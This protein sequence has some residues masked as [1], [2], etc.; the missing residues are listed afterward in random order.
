MLHLAET[1]R[2]SLVSQTGLCWPQWHSQDRKTS[3]Q[4]SD[5][6]VLTVLYYTYYR[7]TIASRAHGGTKCPTALPKLVLPFCA[8]FAGTETALSSPGRSVANQECYPSW[9]RHDSSST[10]TWP[11]KYSSLA[12]LVKQSLQ[13]PSCERCGK[14]AASRPASGLLKCLGKHLCLTFLL[15]PFCLACICKP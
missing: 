7:P 11:C 8:T 13:S 3:P 2:N 10:P 12:L 1:L 6:Q 9:E 15:L 4:G 5:S 14:H